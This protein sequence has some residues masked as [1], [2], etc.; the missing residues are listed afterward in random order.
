M[1]AKMCRFLVNTV[2]QDASE[3][4][5]RQL[6]HMS[7]KGLQVLAKKDLLPDWKGTHPKPC[8][9]CLVGK[10]TRAPL[11]NLCPIKR[12]ALEKVY[13]DVCEMSDKSLGGAFYLLP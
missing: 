9:H 12:L 8:V 1:K 10:Q 11:W 7:E 2:E 5:H 3:I 6:G 13:S 4:L